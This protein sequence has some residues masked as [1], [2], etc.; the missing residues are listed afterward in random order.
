MVRGDTLRI[1]VPELELN[2]KKLL[3]GEMAKTPTPFPT[4]VFRVA[5][6]ETEL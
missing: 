5:R 3:V 2:V 6:N 1:A 4:V